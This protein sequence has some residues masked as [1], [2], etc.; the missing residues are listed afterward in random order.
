MSD[1]TQHPQN[2]YHSY[3]IKASAGSGKTYQLSRRF[4]ALVAAHADPSKILTITFTR[5]AAA[6]M[7][8]RI[9]EEAAH[10]IK[11]R[12]TQEEFNALLTAFYEL[13][14]TLKRPGPQLP[15]PLPAH[16]V[17]HRILSQ[18]QTLAI[19]TIDS[20]FL[21][22]LRQFPFDAGWFSASDTQ[23][24]SQIGDIL[25]PWQAAQ[26]DDDAWQSVFT[27]RDGN[28][29]PEVSWAIGHNLFE[30]M[31]KTNELHR[32]AGLMQQGEAVALHP[33]AAELSENDNGSLGLLQQQKGDLL[34]VAAQLSSKNQPAIWGAVEALDLALMVKLKFL[35]QDLSFHGVTVNKERLQNSAPY[36]NYER[37]RLR[38]L[39]GTKFRQLNQQTQ[40]YQKLYHRWWQERQT[41]KK[42]DGLLE[43]DD[44]LQGA[45]KLFTDS[46]AGGARFMIHHR[47]Q[48]LMLDEFQ[49]TSL[50]QWQIFA[51]ISQELL[52]GSGLHDNKL[53]RPSCFIVGD[54]KQS[55]YG[56][57]EADPEVLLEAANLVAE[58]HGQVVAMN[59]SYRSSAVILDFVNLSCHSMRDF[60]THLA[61]KNTQGI[62]LIPDHGAIGMI[63]VEAPRH[64][65]VDQVTCEAEQVAATIAAMLSDP[66]SYPVWDK[67]QK[68]FRPIVAKDMALLF[69]QATHIGIF[70]RA[71]RK[72]GIRYKRDEGAGFYARQECQDILALFRWLFLPDATHDLLAILRSPLF[73]LSDH[74]IN[75]I[76]ELN[77]RQEELGFWS[78]LTTLEPE[79]AL[80][81]E[82][83]KRRAIN[84]HPQET[85]A[86][87]WHQMCL[88]ERYISIFPEEERPQLDANL[89]KLKGILL[90]LAESQNPLQF[91]AKLEELEQQDQEPLAQVGADAVQLLT[92]HKSKG[93]EYSCVFLVA[94]HEAWHKP[95][96]YWIKSRQDSERPELYFIGTKDEQPEQDLHFERL[97]AQAQEQQLAENDR[98]LYVALT[99]AKHYLIV[100]GL[101]PEPEASAK[102]TTAHL[103]PRLIQAFNQCHG[104]N[105]TLSAGD[106]GTVTWRWRGQATTSTM[107]AEK[108]NPPMPIEA[109][110]SQ[111]NIL[112]PQFA[113]LRPH[114]LQERS[115]G[116]ESMSGDVQAVILETAQKGY[117]RIAGIFIHKYLELKVREQPLDPERIWRTLLNREGLH[118][119]PSDTVYQAILAEAEQVAKDATWQQLVTR[120]HETFCE[121]GFVYREQNALYRGSIDL[122]VLNRATAHVLVVDYKTNAWAGTQEEL[123]QFAV[124]A[125]YQAQID[126]Y[127]QAL[128]AGLPGEF[129]VSGALYF[130]KHRLLLP[131]SGPV[132]PGD[133]PKEAPKPKRYIQ[134]DL[135]LE[136]M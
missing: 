3:V 118:P 131:M 29:D 23:A 92:I 99:R 65:K 63:Q 25:E 90:N 38:Y 37:A 11:N 40:H 43:F 22:W 39:N 56:F 104:E 19:T 16:E 28:T 135:G 98:L 128:T 91:C 100:T 72:H 1:L 59:Q 6:E 61:A 27:L 50:P 58:F 62:D 107:K 73:V 78:C 45:L 26:L 30:V 5:K 15:P 51:A 82:K 13:D 36:E 76:L 66:S 46:E 116:D 79:L 113:I 126:A 81:L 124:Q 48:H 94:C 69:R 7:R 64:K 85:V 106:Q 120:P 20:T 42:R 83:L 103:W 47:I 80:E 102:K 35:K 31:R 33:G 134:L 44:A 55:I 127:R 4:L 84:W 17:G 133:A 97:L 8:S 75:R 32:Y 111:S 108:A 18:S 89:A 105:R 114:A 34:A 95:E 2:P 52:S 21:Q 129:S 101:K 125:G 74:R 24:L 132:W 60:A 54:L 70:E 10:L 93:L 41:N 119:T 49:D 110:R 53:T 121:W 136:E 122:I 68:L 77:L 57:R 67:G 117:E 130:T 87:L 14:V 12:T 71:L 96:R 86:Q 115:E 88:P 112:R 109:L 123:R 9:L